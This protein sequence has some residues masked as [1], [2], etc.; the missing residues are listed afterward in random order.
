M[1]LLQIVILFIITWRLFPSLSTLLLI[2]AGTEVL[3]IASPVV[4]IVH[5]AFR[6]PK[7]HSETADAGDTA[8]ILALDFGLFAGHFSAIR[9][10]SEAATLI[11]LY[12]SVQ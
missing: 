10:R 8:A 2:I 12:N 5:F 7:K 3:C 9:C 6:K 4:Q 1:G 11:L